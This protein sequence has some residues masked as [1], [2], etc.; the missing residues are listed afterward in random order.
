MAWS[1]KSV[2][3]DRLSI[4]RAKWRR[5]AQSQTG[6]A[7]GLPGETHQAAWAP[8]RM[9]DCRKESPARQLR[10][11][12]KVGCCAHRLSAHAGGA[13]GGGEL[14]PLSSASRDG[15]VGIDGQRV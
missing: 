11:G 7:E 5:S 2:L 14:G 3:L 1:T 9:L 12:H 4:P 8:L 6:P 10:A 15:D 13:Q